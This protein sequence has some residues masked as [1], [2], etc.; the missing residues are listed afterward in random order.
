MP[1]QLF[2]II[3]DI[4]VVSNPVTFRPMVR[5]RGET[6][7]EVGPEDILATA[8]YLIHDLVRIGE[9]MKPH[10]P[11]C[12][13]CRDQIYDKL[14]AL[15]LEELRELVWHS[16]EAQQVLTEKLESGMQTEHEQ[17]WDAAM[18]VVKVG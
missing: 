17:K 9:M 15:T 13:E 12:N 5:F 16:D 14:R 8:V 3:R 1:K 11:E 10:A 18:S 4:E 7:L 6:A 2:N